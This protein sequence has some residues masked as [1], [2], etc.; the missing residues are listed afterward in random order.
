MTLRTQPF[1]VIALIVGYLDLDDV[2]NLSICSRHFRSL[3]YDQTICKKVLQ[4]GSS[5][6]L[7]AQQ[8][9]QDHDYARGLR[10]LIKR[11]EAISSAS[12]FLT[13]VVAFA[14][15]WSYE[16][17]VLCHIRERQ[18]R[19]LDVHYSADKEIVVDIRKLLDEAIPESKGSRK[20]KF[21]LLYQAHGIV[22]CLYTH[23]RPH[24]AHWLVVFSPTE[25]KILT[26]R[27]LDS[28][29]KIFARSNSDFL[30]Y[31]VQS[32][33]G[34]DGFRRWVLEGFDMRQAT[35]FEDSLNLPDTVGSDIDSTICFEIIDGY[36][37]VLT[38][39]TSFELDKIGYTP[40]KRN[41]FR[42]QHSEGPIDDRWTFMKIF[43]DELSGELKILES[44]KEWLAGN[45]TA[46]RTYYIK[47]LHM[48]ERSEARRSFSGSD[49]EE[50]EDQYAENDRLAQ[51]LGT[52]SKSNKGRAPSRD[53]GEVHVGD[54]GATSVM[55]TLSKCF[56]RSYHPSSH[57]FMDLVDDPHKSDPCGQRIRIRAGARLPRARSGQAGRSL[58]VGNLEQDH[59]QTQ[60]QEQL[61]NQYEQSGVVYWPPEGRSRALDYLHN[62]L[63]PPGF[64]GNVQGTWDTRSLIYATGGEGNGGVKALVLVSFDP[65]IYLRGS[66]S[67]KHSASVGED[68]LAARLRNIQALLNPE[69]SKGKKGKEADMVF[70]CPSILDE[71]VVVEHRTSASAGSGLGSRGR[72][73]SAVEAGTHAWASYEPA[74]YL[75]INMGLHFA[76]S[77]MPV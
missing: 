34:D 14:E 33:I 2:S 69:A 76:E 21:Q 31:G 11:R 57:T 3:A 45:S 50:W 23:A 10:R 8:A 18:L 7:E 46:T 27:R 55:F 5:S 53:P 49:E 72:G 77:G 22:S 47:T 37:C 59:M 29:Y 6:A 67:F 17:G 13:A 54:D 48:T 65:S 25:G 52:A 51:Y 1:E 63:N 68:D 70:A 74:Q 60:T 35:W 64:A 66:R 28:V 19:L 56:I 32:D 15:S 26:T 24:P 12:P 9:H 36:F 38:N 44:R 40:T 41:L 71:E 20:Y 30:Y 39:N 73:C 43:C 42:R 62:V 61:D 16:N 58:V 4:T 75:T